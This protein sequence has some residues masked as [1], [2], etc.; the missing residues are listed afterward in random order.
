MTPASRVGR[1]TDGP[2]DDLLAHERLGPATGRRLVL[3]HGF[4]Q[5][6]ACWPGVA[7][8]LAADH[9]LVLVDAPGHGGSV[10]P[11]LAAAD[12]PAGA[13]ALGR[14]GGRA[15]YL[16]YSMGGRYCLRLALDRPDLV[17]RLVVVGAHPGLRDR[18]ERAARRAD[19]EAL[20]DHLELV[21]VDTFLDEWLAL[22][23][24]A[25][26]PPDARS[27]AA[28]RTNS[29]DGLAASLRHAGTGTQE[30]LWD[31]LGTLADHGVPSLWVTGGLDA[32]FD[33]VAAEAVASIGPNATHVRIPGAGHTAHLERPVAFLTALRAWLRETDGASRAG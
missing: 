25:G 2:H 5:T 3:V 15:T 6:R 4:T 26:L 18:D 17:E 30:P 11:A 1:V 24:F 14:T 33:A 10:T 12:L 16:G 32:K 20:A 7:E 19:D 28:R 8:D 21:G 22:P 27:L 29:T 13:A 9:D 23:L 31:R